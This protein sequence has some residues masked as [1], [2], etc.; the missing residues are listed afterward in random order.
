[1]SFL[2]DI[3]DWIGGYPYEFASVDEIVSFFC[4]KGFLLKYIKTTTR[5]GNNQYTFIKINS[6]HV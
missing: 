1:M 2:T 3:E 4:D 6:N 5:T